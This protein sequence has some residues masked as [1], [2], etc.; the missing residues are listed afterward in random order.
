MV[1]AVRSA[2]LIA[3][4]TAP[5]CIVF[6]VVTVAMLR[7]PPDHYSFYPRCPIYTAFH[8][9]CPG[10][11]GTRALSAL[12]RG[13]LH[14]ALRLNGLVTLFSPILLLALIPSKG[15]RFRRFFI[16]PPQSAVYAALVITAIF[17]FAR[18]L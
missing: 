11:G 1:P 3:R 14:V 2:L 4:R 15:I 16:A 10:C 8:L 7:F 9:Q 6:L 5:P 12:L 18:N 17:T 13:D